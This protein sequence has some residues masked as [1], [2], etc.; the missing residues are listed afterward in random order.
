MAFADPTTQM[1]LGL[2]E[3]VLMNPPE[4]RTLEKV[5]MILPLLRTRSPLFYNLD[6]DIL[7]DIATNASLKKIKRDHA[8]IWQ[9]QEG[10]NFGIIIKG[11]A[12]VHARKDHGRVPQQD[13]VSITRALRERVAMVGPELG[14]ISAGSSFGEMAMS[15]DHLPYNVTVIADELVHVLLINRTLYATSFGAHKLEWEKKVEFVNQSPLFRH[16]TPALKDLLMENL[17][18]REIQFG[19]RFIKQGGVCNCL[20]FV[21]S[22]W[23]KV[24]ADLRIS[25]T[26]YEA[27]KTTSKGKQKALGRKTISCDREYIHNKKLDPTRP[28]SVIDRRKHMQKFGYVAIETLLRQ[29]EVPVTSTGPNDVIGDI[30]VIMNFPTY[31]ASMECI[32]TLHVYELSKFNFYQIINQRSTKT[33]DLLRKG[34]LAKLHFRAQ[35]L[36]DIPLYTL[37]LEQAL[38]PVEDPTRKSSLWTKKSI[39]IKAMKKVLGNI[40]KTQQTPGMDK[41]IDSKEARQRRHSGNKS[42]DK[43]LDKKSAPKQYTVAEFRALKKKMQAMEGIG[44]WRTLI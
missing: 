3:S 23:G 1:M 38:S 31:C 8:V 17:K 30:E 13:T 27:I 5:C 42:D 7:V 14:H 32:E 16:L 37:L 28:L 34:A 11:A 6:K 26:Q 4:C 44:G 2:M 24:V 33:Y 9:G 43:Q 12:S 22:G 40:S 35:R 41:P 20:F 10:N 39:Q 25:R 36:K 15:C 19:N 21:R 29:R 18:P